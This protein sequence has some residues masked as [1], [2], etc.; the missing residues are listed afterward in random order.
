MASHS[1][2]FSTVEVLRGD[3]WIKI[4]WGSTQYCLGFFDARKD[5][6]P[7]PAMRMVR[8]RPK[9]DP[10]VV[11]SC[12]ARDDVNIGQVAG[13]P[14][15]EQYERAANRALEMAQHIRHRHAFHPD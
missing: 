11:D 2:A 1:A 13:F 7:R 15:P 14:S 4:V 6:A 5:V 10:L 9:K 12:P 3:E 8:H